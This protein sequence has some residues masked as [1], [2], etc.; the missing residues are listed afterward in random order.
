MRIFIF[1]S[2]FI[3]L[4]TLTLKAYAHSKTVTLATHNLCPYG[5]YDEHGEFSG[6]AVN[7]VKY[8]MAQMNFDLR[9]EVVPWKR[10]QRMSYEGDADGFFAASHSEKRDRNGVMSATIAGQIW[11]W[12][13]LKTNTLDPKSDNFKSEAKVAAFSGSNMLHWLKMNNY[14]VVA[15]PPSTKH[16]MNML[17]YERFDAMLGN[18]LTMKRYIAKQNLA[19]Q[20]KSTAYKNKPVGVYFSNRFIEA[21]PGFITEFNKHVNEYRKQ[22]ASP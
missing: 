10:A 16:L 7:V 14:N 19:G 6:T 5:C 2:T 15:E 3:I 8:A 20:I 13:Q 4:L 18:N 12:Y 9:I 21:H 1:C 17:L 11:K 22:P